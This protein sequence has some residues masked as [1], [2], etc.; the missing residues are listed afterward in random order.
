MIMKCMRLPERMWRSR[1]SSD[2]DSDDP[3]VHSRCSIMSPR[4]PGSRPDN[5]NRMS[6][7]PQE[8]R[9]RSRTRGDPWVA[10]QSETGA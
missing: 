8:K 4:E 10:T 9:G 5:R 3:C 1:N 2:D 6:F 7:T